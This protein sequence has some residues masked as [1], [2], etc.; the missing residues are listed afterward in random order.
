MLATKNGL[1][2][3]I[4][5]FE[6]SFLAFGK[7]SFSGVKKWVFK[8]KYP[9]WLRKKKLPTHLYWYSNPPIQHFN[10]YLCALGDPCLYSLHLFPRHLLH[11]HIQVWYFFFTEKKIKCNILI[12]RKRNIFNLQDV[13]RAYLSEWKTRPCIDGMLQS[14]GS[15][16]YHFGF[17]FSGK[18]RNIFYMK[19][20]KNPLK[21]VFMGRVSYCPAIMD[22]VESKRKRCCWADTQNSSADSFENF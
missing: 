17:Q 16:W 1:G 15:Y 10:I 20:K 3:F 11:Q 9:H 12:S 6:N 13:T 7:L 4:W 18:W 2:F 19:R 21:K 8:F 14:I 5:E 22:I